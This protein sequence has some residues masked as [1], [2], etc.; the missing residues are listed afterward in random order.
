[1]EVLGPCVT[2]LIGAMNCKSFFPGWSDFFENYFLNENEMK[3]EM[4]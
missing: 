3:M 4:K 2:F 1:M